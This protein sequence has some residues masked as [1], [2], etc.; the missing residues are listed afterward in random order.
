MDETLIMS[1]GTFCIDTFVDNLIVVSKELLLHLEV[2]ATKFKLS[3]M[4]DS[5][6]FFLGSNWK[7]DDQNTRVSNEAHMRE[8]IRKFEE[9]H[10]DTRMESVPAP[11]K[12][13]PP[14]HAEADDSPLL[15]PAHLRLYQSIIGTCQWLCKSGRLGTTFVLSSLS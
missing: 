5:L 12:S 2:L 7:N 13:H 3:N 15:D 6:T 1:R 11:T 9:E 14:N 8:C 4:H 10:E